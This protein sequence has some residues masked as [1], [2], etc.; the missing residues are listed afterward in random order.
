MVLQSWLTRLRW[1]KKGDDARDALLRSKALD[2]VLQ[3][4]TT[5]R[6]GRT[7]IQVAAQ[8]C[9]GGECQRPLGAVLVLMSAVPTALLGMLLRLLA[10]SIEV[11]DQCRESGMQSAES[12]AAE[13]GKQWVLT[14]LT[15]ALRD[16]REVH[17]LRK[18]SSIE[19]VDRAFPLLSA[20]RKPE[21]PDHIL[22]RAETWSR[23]FSELKELCL[24]LA[25]AKPNAFKCD[26]DVAQKSLSVV[27]DSLGK[28][29]ES[30][31]NV[32]SRAMCR[33]NRGKKLFLEVARASVELEALVKVRAEKAKLIAGALPQLLNHKLGIAALCLQ[34]ESERSRHLTAIHAEVHRVV[35]GAQADVLWED[36][37]ALPALRAVLKRTLGLVEQARREMVHL[38]AQCLD[39]NNALFAKSEEMSRASNNYKALV[40]ELKKSSSRLGKMEESSKRATG[41][42]GVTAA[43]L[44]NLIMPAPPEVVDASAEDKALLME[45]L[46]CMQE[47][48]KMLCRAAGS[49]PP[50]PLTL[51][52][53]AHTPPDSGKETNATS[54]PPP[55]AKAMVAALQKTAGPVAAP[56]PEAQQPAT[57]V[58]SKG[59]LACADGPPQPVEHGAVEVVDMRPEAVQAPRPFHQRP[60]VATWLGK[61]I[62]LALVAAAQD[63][64]LESALP[65]EQR[66][67][68]DGL[69]YYRSLIDSTSIE[70]LTEVFDSLDPKARLRVEDALKKS[71]S[72]DHPD[73][74]RLYMSSIDAASMEQ[75]A[76]VFDSLDPKARLRL[77]D[78]MKSLK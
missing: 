36:A 57:M 32:P 2:I 16:V 52:T 26:Q 27:V 21:K 78:A 65:R 18:G 49:P 22:D 8:N 14:L 70:I 7:A 59:G 17:L 28:F 74:L 41:K 15:S 60:S 53:P 10:E 11:V 69:E 72:K 3:T 1:E 55:V 35:W 4:L 40:E 56:K 73:Q 12:E 63:K 33:S 34:A 42:S 20:E 23:I 61:T 5:C 76:E 9:A 67:N 19:T 48:H 51:E 38:A 6:S 77:E 50:A 68:E 43:S 29:R 47:L 24:K 71:S 58:T 66:I 62:P 75:L 30:M 64:T 13:R 46:K 39:D 37:T 31:E 25:T 44:W 45:R 54:S